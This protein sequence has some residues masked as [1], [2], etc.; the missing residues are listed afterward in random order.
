MALIRRIGFTRFTRF[1]ENLG[2][3]DVRAAKHTDALD[4]TDELAITCTDDLAKG[5]RI[6]WVDFGGKAHE[7]IVDSLSRTHDSDGQRLTEATC[8][9]SI[10]ETW[11]DYVEDKRP[12]GTADVALQSVLSGTRWSVG[13]CDVKTSTSHTFYHESVREA[14]GELL[15]AWGGE[16][17]TSITVD[18]PSVSGR[19]VGIRALR[20]DQSSPKRFVWTKDLVSVKRSVASE[21]PKSRIYGYGKGVE[22]DTGG[23]GRRLTFGD[24]NGGRDY[25]E[26][27]DAQ[28]LW[29]H[30]ASDGTVAPS[31]GVF[32]D[33]DC[34]DAATLLQ[35]TKDYL[36]SVKEPKVTYEADVIDLYAFGRSWERVETGDSVAIIDR[37]FTDDGKGIRLKGRVTKTERDLLAGGATVTFGNLTDQF[38]DMW[39]SVAQSLRSSSSA[40]ATYDAAAA[41]SPGW[42]TLLQGALNDQFNNAGTYKVETFELGT[43]YSNVPIDALTGL[44]L[45]S[46]SGMWAVNLNGMGLRLASGLTSD[47]QWDWKTFLTGGMVTADLINAGTMRADRVRA[48]LLTD[49]KGKNFWN[50]S[51]GEFSLSGMAKDTDLDGTVVSVDVLFGQNDSYTSPP[52]AWSTTAP[53]WVDGMFIWSKTVTKYHDGTTSET[54]PACITGARGKAG[55]SVT[56]KSIAYAPGTSGTVAP[57]TGWTTTVPNVP[58]GMWLWCRTTYSDGTQADTCSHMGADGADG[59]SVAVESVTKSGKTTTVT[60]KDTSGKTTTLRITDGKDGD[61]G[62]PGAEGYVHI[63]WSTSPTGSSGFSTSESANKTY[64]GIYADHTKADSTNPSDY[65]WTLIKG[66]G[67]SAIVEQYYL[68]TSST[69]QTGG[70]WQTTQPS[71][72]SGKFIWT[73]NVIQWT[74]NETEYTAPQLA[75]G[76][77]GANQNA[78]NAKDAADKANK[79]L[80][81][82]N[83]QEGVFNKLTSNGTIKGIFMKDGQLLVNASYINSGEIDASEVKIKNL[84]QVGT[85]SDNVSVTEDG[86]SFETNGTPGAM[87][88]RPAGYV[89]VE[90]STFA[91]NWTYLCHHEGSSTQAGDSA[92]ATYTWSVSDGALG[93]AAIHGGASMVR[94]RFVFRYYLEG[95][96]AN[97]DSGEVYIPGAAIATGSYV[98]VYTNNDMGDA[99]F[100]IAVKASSPDST[101]QDY[102]FTYQTTSHAQRTFRLLS[103]SVR[104]SIAKTG[105]KIETKDGDVVVT[106]SNFASLTGGYSGEFRVPYVYGNTMRNYCMKFVDGLLVDTS[107]LTPS[108]DGYI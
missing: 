59:N 57:S 85:D 101:T 66:N 29:G 2:R 96:Y 9:N 82:L 63:A 83:T 97:C 8:I 46:T 84:M 12:S 32:V 62:T 3:L 30:P 92:S 74:N 91:E 1:G 60:L 4:G 47:G 38:A 25:V 5:D 99:T 40:R 15:D 39:E 56:V 64:I 11:D 19:S 18:G 10:N 22:T 76:L 89:D 73:R 70:Y 105:A 102:S 41:A 67:V 81:T 16:L 49:E 24:V 95:T 103:I 107:I 28:A 23:Y 108:D 75:N 78:K 71:W 77:N 53:K 13:T 80:A 42:L 87:T 33:E 54:V 51:T 31:V 34:D 69:T 26:D 79:T 104:A 20:G 58:Q 48:G 17:E 43:I 61:T 36:E 7:H 37:G 27:T 88:I 93:I 14:I 100:T 52:T 68:S 72:S 45:R 50:L 90:H 6:V 94:F 35:E 86:I 44:P 55:S 106:N 65:S 98:N 21:N